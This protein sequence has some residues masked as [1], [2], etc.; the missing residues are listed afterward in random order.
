MHQEDLLELLL[1]DHQVREDKH[2][3]WQLLN[4]LVSY[5]FQLDNF[6]KLRFKTTQK[7]VK[8]LLVAPKK[9]KQFQIKLLIILLS[10]DLDRVIAESTAGYWMD[11]HILNLKSI[12]SRLWESNHLLLWFSSKLRMNPLEDLETEE[13][14]QIVELSTTWKLILQ[15]MSQLLTVW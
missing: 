5:G 2:S 10:K 8:S 7:M 14:I 1:L 12:Y 9:E 13:L 4:S 3:P 15:V 6:W 11:S